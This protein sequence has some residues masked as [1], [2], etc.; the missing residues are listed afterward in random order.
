MILLQVL[1]FLHLYKHIFFEDFCNV[2]LHSSTLKLQNMK[3]RLF[4]LPYNQCTNCSSDQ[5]KLKYVFI[6]AQ[7]SV[8]FWLTYGHLPVL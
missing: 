3:Y 8:L 2:I 4:I 1:L 6:I 7:D 5:I